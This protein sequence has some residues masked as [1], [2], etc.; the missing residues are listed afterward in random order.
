[1]HRRK[2]SKEAAENGDGEYH[3]GQPSADDKTEPELPPANGATSPHTRSRTL[4]GYGSGPRLP[5]SPQRTQVPTR[6][7]SL[8][9][10]DR[11]PPSAPSSRQTFG[12]LAP[13]PITSIPMN[14]HSRAPS[15]YEP[16]YGS[17][18]P[19]AGPTRTSFGPTSPTKMPAS[20]FRTGFPPASPSTGSSAN[21]GSPQSLQPGRRSHA[22]VHSRNLSVYFP[23]PGASSGGAVESIAEDGDGMDEGQEIEVGTR[24]GEAPIQLIPPPNA[25]GPRGFAD[26]FRF[27]GLPADAG[28]PA[29]NDS[30]A[31]KRRGHHHKHSLSHNFFSFM[32]PTVTKVS[33]AYPNI[34]TPIPAT[35]SSWGPIT[36]FPQSTTTPAFSNQSPLIPEPPRRGRSPLHAPHEKSTWGTYLRELPPGS[37]RALV[38]SFAEFLV[39][40][41]MWVAGQRRGSLACTGLGYWVVFDAMGVAMGVVGRELREG[42]AGAGTA[43]LPFGTAR[44]EV[45]MLF[46]QAVYLMFAAVYICK[47]TVEHLLLAAGS[48][49]HHHSGDD[50]AYTP[51]GLLFPN[52]LLCLSTLSILFAGIVFQTHDRLVHATGSDLPSLSTLFRFSS[53]TSRLH[54]LLDNPFCVAPIVF[55]CTLLGVSGF[56]ASTEHR[57][58]DLALAAAETIV[59]WMVAYPSALALGKVL[60]QTAPERG[61]RDARIEGFLRVMRE[62]ERHPQIMHLPAPRLWRLTPS[63]GALVATIELHVRKGVD[64]AEVLALTR[65][66]YERCLAVVGRGGGPGSVTVSV[67]RG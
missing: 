22:R 58:L 21:G 10:Y 55:G 53:S 29:M 19:S 35:P 37:K 3:N 6:A 13:P 44:L 56:V 40:A 46:A 64:D 16:L 54:A 17:G 20:P 2:T 41:A 49:H 67:V 23:R 24:N 59:T 63:S 5:A 9:T 50:D 31:P 1:M 26:G 36:P 43:K 28:A 42:D 15:V 33:Q 18:P 14:R 47:E 52:V 39:G 30:A 11:P 48:S 60:L 27:G 62:L 61:A 51:E 57:S 32:E 34:A 8:N 4:P 38:Y 65:Y 12:S 25:N 7:P 45:T 66:A